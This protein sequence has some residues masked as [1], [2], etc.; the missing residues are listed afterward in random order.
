MSNYDLLWL[1]CI[2]M[3]INVI[4]AIGLIVQEH[5]RKYA[6]KEFIYEQNGYPYDWKYQEAVD[7]LNDQNRAA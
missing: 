1:V 7:I 4:A 6:P 2:L 3:T 5:R